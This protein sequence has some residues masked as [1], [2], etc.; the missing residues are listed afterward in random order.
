VKPFRFRAA[1]V[2]EWR[3]TAADAARGAFMRA[4]ESARETAEQVEA[5]EARRHSAE[6]SLRVDLGSPIDAPTLT[7]HRNWIDRQRAAVTA[8][9]ILHD[10]RVAAVA[11]AAT[12]LQDAARHVKVLER[13]RERALRRHQAAE[14][15]E[16]MQRLDEFAVQQFARSRTQGEKEHGR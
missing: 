14:R 7:R 15:R 11:A 4:R 3:M 16:E 8:H 1:R 2:L 13:L 9:Q 6:D 5:A 10:E 12:V